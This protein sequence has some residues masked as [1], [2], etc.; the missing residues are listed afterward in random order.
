[1]YKFLVFLLA[2][3]LAGCVAPQYQTQYRLTPPTAAAGKICLTRCD[4]AARQCKNQCGVKL[5]QCALQAS[6]QA[7]RD[8]PGKLE[9]WEREMAVWEHEMARYETDLQFWEMEMRQRRLMHDLLRDRD[10]CRPGDRQCI[11]H[12]PLGGFGYDRWD[13]PVS[14]GSAPKRP[15]LATESARIQ[16]AICNDTCPCD[17]QYRLCYGSC[18]GLVQSYQVQMP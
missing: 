4:A 18:G 7:K 2:I 17:D 11:R 5:Q 14:P 9:A 3:G 10:R 13:R 15:T 8:L 1:M 12:R 16:E 6:Q